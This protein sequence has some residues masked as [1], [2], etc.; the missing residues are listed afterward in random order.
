MFFLPF[1]RFLSTPVFVAGLICIFSAQV[2]FILWLS[3]CDH[4]Q[5]SSSNELLLCGY[6]TSWHDWRHYLHP[7]NRRILFG[8]TFLPAFVVIIVTAQLVEGL[9]FEYFRAKL[10]C[11]NVPLLWFLFA[12]FAVYIW[13]LPCDMS[14]EPTERGGFCGYL[15]TSPYDWR[16]YIS[17]QQRDDLSAYTVFASFA[18]IVFIF[19]SSGKNCTRERFWFIAC[20]VCNAIT[21]WLLS[22]F[23][24]PK[25]CYSIGRG[26]WYCV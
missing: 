15:S 5:R 2:A 7:D 14:F 4:A 26:G 18:T 13:T 1:P 9:L 11:T 20:M 12:L 16:H 23:E 17:E 19:A 8:C 21:F 3:P 24:Q 25:T 10:N 22:V 6:P